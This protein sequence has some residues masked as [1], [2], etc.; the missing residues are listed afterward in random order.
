[1]DTDEQQRAATVARYLR[2]DPNTVR[3]ALAPIL[4]L[5]SD[6]SDAHASVVSVL[7][8]KSHQAICHRG[9][10]ITMLDAMDRGATPATA[11]VESE[12][13][14]VVDS[15]AAFAAFGFPWVCYVGVPMLGA[16]GSA[17]GSLSLLLEPGTTV[18]SQLLGQCHTIGALVAD[19]LEMLAARTEDTPVSHHD[20]PSTNRDISPRE[21]REA[22]AAGQI[23]P[24]FQPVVDLAT[25]ARTSVEALARWLH[26]TLGL[27]PPAQ[28]IP[29]AE[30]SSLVVDLDLEIWRRALLAV[31]QRRLVEPELRLS[32]NFSARHTQMTSCPD[33]LTELAQRSGV[34]PHA[35]DVELTESTQMG[36]QAVAVLNEVRNRGFSVLLDDFG[37]GWA[38]LESVLVLPHDGL[39]VDRYITQKIGSPQGQA[40]FRGITAGALDRG[41]RTIAEGV[42]TAEQ[43]ALVT[44]MGFT[45]GQGYYWGRPSPTLDALVPAQRVGAA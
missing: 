25:G 17:V 12:R 23:V 36:R 34:P 30:R 21:I 26:P 11:V 1:M 38:T 45:H 5:L 14:V 8:D 18:S 37:T 43:A 28:F 16:G 13:P 9:A 7:D 10:P 33:Q 24:F 41:V 29:V 20:E 42:E 3:Q 40:V 35:V 19:Q 6:L 15:T 31:A 27:V 4:S 2:L 39:K 44:E 22:L 32:V